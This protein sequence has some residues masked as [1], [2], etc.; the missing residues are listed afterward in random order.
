MYI[1]IIIPIYAAKVQGISPKIKD[2]RTT[3]VRKFNDDTISFLNVQIKSSFFF[4][5]SVMYF[6]MF[7]FCEPPHQTESCIALSF[8]SSLI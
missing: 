5:P 4:S 1:G 8:L 6:K 2:I 3:T 7:I